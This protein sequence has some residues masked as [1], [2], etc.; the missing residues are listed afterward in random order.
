MPNEIYDNL[1][2]TPRETEI[3]NLM[4]EG[5]NV[6]E[7]AKKIISSKLHSCYSQVSNLSKERS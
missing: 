4:L 3:Y 2:L 6:K 1:F 5:L 7:I